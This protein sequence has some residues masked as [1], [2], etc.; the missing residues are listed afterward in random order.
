MATILSSLARFSQMPQ[1]GVQSLKAAGSGDASKSQLRS[2]KAGLQ[3]TTHSVWAPVHLLAAV[4]E[5]S[6][7]EILELAG[8]AT[9][10]NKKHRIVPRHLQLA[11]RNDE[12]LGKRCTPFPCPCSC[13]P[14]LLGSIT[15]SL[16]GAVPH[17]DPS[18]LPTTQ[19]SSSLLARNSRFAEGKGAAAEQQ[20][21]TVRGHFYGHYDFDLDNTVY[22]HVYCWAIRVCNK[23]IDIFIEALAW[24]NYRFQKVNSTVTVVAFIIM[25]ASTHSYTI[26]SYT[27]EAL[28]GQAVITQLCNTVTKIQN[29]IGARP[30]ESPAR[31]H[32]DSTSTGTLR[33][34]DKLLSDEDL[35]LLKRRIFVL[36]RNSL[37]LIPRHNMV[38]DA[39]D[40]IWNQIC[41]VRLFNN[42]S[43][44]FK[45][46]LH[47]D[48]LN[49]SNLILGLDYEEFVRGT[50][51]SS[52]DETI[53]LQ[54][55]HK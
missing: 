37:P 44:C 22:V 51:L 6:A 49:S 15:I 29:H 54:Q 50:H 24:L 17:I 25:P 45:I 11:I 27:I 31:S 28:K 32:G 39:N 14:K 23:G 10:D 46:V 35:I 3:A 52:A 21:S 53:K 18:L 20:R 55:P 5:Y 19:S 40:P 26:D 43:D 7:A 30:F 47:P 2:S 9:R 34:T 42:A 33:N 41:R 36:K 4:L 48:F 16:G 1:A 13:R 8:N 38:D 12:E